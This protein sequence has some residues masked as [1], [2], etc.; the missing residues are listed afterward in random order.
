MRA[1]IPVSSQAARRFLATGTLAGPNRA[2][3]VDPLWRA[4]VPDVDEEVWEYEAAQLAADS[5]AGL[6]GVVLAAEVS[7]VGPVAD[8]ATEV[9]DQLARRDIAA[10]LTADMAWYGLQE[11]GELLESLGT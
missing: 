6:A 9:A 11:L 1:Y 8:G 2:W 5:L 7:Q 3:V 10:V 4:G